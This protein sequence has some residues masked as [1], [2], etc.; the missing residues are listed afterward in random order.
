MPVA[1]ELCQTKWWQHT[2]IPTIMRKSSAWLSPSWH[3]CWCVIKSPHQ[4][5]PCGVA[6]H[7]CLKSPTLIVTALTDAALVNLLE[8]WTSLHFELPS[9][10]RQSPLINPVQKAAQR[11][12]PQP[13]VYMSV[14]SG[15]KV[16][17]DAAVGS[18][19]DVSRLYRCR[20]GRCALA[21]RAVL[22]ERS[23]RGF[24]RCLAHPH[25]KRCASC[26]RRLLRPFVLHTS[27][28]E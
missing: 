11:K 23:Y 12:P 25:L 17:D 6:P 1:S 28:N 26:R 8:I 24:I 15:F 22:F 2:T 3:L 27:A 4:N 14:A 19:A 7:A 21:F 18:P 10:S 20:S 9:A 5:T 16:A 13:L